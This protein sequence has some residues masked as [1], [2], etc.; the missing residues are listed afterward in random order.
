[1][2]N[3]VYKFII[4]DETQ[5]SQNSPIAGQTPSGSSSASS[6]NKSVSR[7]QLSG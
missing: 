5:E 2:E 4:T 1:M 3:N 7:G 6:N